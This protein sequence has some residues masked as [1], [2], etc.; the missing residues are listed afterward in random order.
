M[1]GMSSGTQRGAPAIA[2]AQGHASTRSTGPMQA[3]RFRKFYA[4]VN[5]RRIGGRRCLGDYPDATRSDSQGWQSA[6]SR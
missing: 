1:L 3:Q 5:T 6:A 2:T 4:A